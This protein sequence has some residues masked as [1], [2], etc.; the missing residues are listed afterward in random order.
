MAGDHMMMA[1]VPESLYKALKTGKAMQKNGLRSTK[2]HFW[3]EQPELFEVGSGCGKAIK[4]ASKALPVGKMIGVGALA[5]VAGTAVKNSM[6]RATLEKE[7]EIMLENERLE[8]ARIR[9]ESR[10][11]KKRIRREVR[12][13]KKK[14]KMEL[15]ATEEKLKMEEEY[16]QNQLLGQ[17]ELLKQQQ[18]ILEQ[19]ERIKRMEYEMQ[20]M[21]RKGG[22][23]NSDD[24]G[25]EVAVESIKHDDINMSQEQYDNTLDIEIEEDHGTDEIEEYVVTDENIDFEEQNNTEMIDENEQDTEANNKF[26]I[27][28][29][30]LSV[31][32]EIAMDN[33]GK[34][35]NDEEAKRHLINIVLLAASISKEIEQLSMRLAENSCA[36][37][38]DY[39]VWKNTMNNIITSRVFIYV[40]EILKTSPEMVS[41]EEREAINEII[42]IG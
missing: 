35:L 17:Q 41:S 37:N 20:L 23:D 12:A 36:E 21:K 42:A 7:R 29:S 2:G 27:T 3:S 14:H 8:R 10:E 31:G 40:N 28:P 6:Q 16:F 24:F 4:A 25:E 39:F 38:E 33:Y 32:M 13:E 15:K 18:L 19:Q 22:T 30:D 26:E 11:D 5:F 34:N 9:K 1:S